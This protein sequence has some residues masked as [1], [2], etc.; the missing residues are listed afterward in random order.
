MTTCPFLRRAEHC[1]G[2]VAEA[3]A[4][5]CRKRE[6]EKKRKVRYLDIKHL[7]I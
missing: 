1:M 6:R 7:D 3:P 5:A 2:K 4:E